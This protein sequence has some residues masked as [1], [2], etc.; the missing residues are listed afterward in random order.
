MPIVRPADGAVPSRRLLSPA[1]LLSDM[2]SCP[3][4]IVSMT[5]RR[6]VC[7]NWPALWL[8]LCFIGRTDVDYVRKELEA[9][10]LVDF[11]WVAPSHPN[12]TPCRGDHLARCASLQ[13][14][15]ISRRGAPCHVSKGLGRNFGR[16][17][18][19]LSASAWNGA[20]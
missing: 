12:K 13:Q 6:R 4:L 3:G 7:F 10:S 19:V 20:G 9:S 8:R 5:F 11:A 17:L 1:L 14:C 16:R 2:Q 15:R 18:Q